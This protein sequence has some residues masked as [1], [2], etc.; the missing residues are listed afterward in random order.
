MTAVS[1]SKLIQLLAISAAFVGVLS[2]TPIIQ[3]LPGTFL[4]GNAVAAGIGIFNTIGQFG[5]F[6]AP[7]IIGITKEQ[8]GSYAAGIMIIAAGLVIGALIV[9]A[10]S[11]TLVSKFM[12]PL[13]GRPLREID[14][15]APGSIAARRRSPRD[16]QRN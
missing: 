13:N 15:P 2:S 10:L 16:R 3:N 4:R 11:H 7:Y 14:D 1:H 12:A 6:V 8:S 5:G 9:V